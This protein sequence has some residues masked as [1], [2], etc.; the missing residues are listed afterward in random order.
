MSDLKIEQM[1]IE[2][3]PQSEVVPENQIP[4]VFKKEIGNRT[5]VRVLPGVSKPSANSVISGHEPPVPFWLVGIVGG[6]GGLLGWF[7][8]AY[9]LP[10]D[11]SFYDPYKYALGPG[12]FSAAIPGA[13][14]GL[15]VGYLHTGSFYRW[16]KGIKFGF[17][18][19]G[20][21][22]VGGALSGIMVQVLFDLFHLS[23]VVDLLMLTLIRA[24]SWG[25]VGLILGLA[26]AVITGSGAKMS[27][28]M[29][30][31]L[32][33]GMMGGALCGNLGVIG[34]T[35]DQ[36]AAV[37]VTFIGL[38]IGL[39]SGLAKEHPYNPKLPKRRF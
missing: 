6:V 32:V 27:A 9:L 1:E 7:L 18:S 14:I 25:S 22:L 30:G 17:V 8:A 3:L 33:G 5:E 39:A 16:P 21:G 13:L 35:S 34:L 11:L 24:F 36:S 23:L 26:A 15:M 37:T 29:L 20:F 28:G 12:I 4:A 2:L 19:L 31:G 38:G 10:E